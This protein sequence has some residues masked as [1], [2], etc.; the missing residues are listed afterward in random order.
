MTSAGADRRPWTS[1]ID[2]FRA[3]RSATLA[4]FRNVSPEAWDRRGIASDNPVTVR[5]LA[6]ITA[7]HVAHHVALLNERYLPQISLAR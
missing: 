4:F 3:V 7:G 2:E 5:A 6:Y 1:H